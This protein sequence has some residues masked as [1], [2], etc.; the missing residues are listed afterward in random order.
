[1]SIGDASGGSTGYPERGT[2]TAL[3]QGISASRLPP[4]T[5]LANQE[6]YIVEIV[7]LGQIILTGALIVGF[8]IDVL[9]SS[10]AIER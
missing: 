4:Y 8:S 3:A 1:M 6:E 5:A 9:Q 2:P 7:I 10:L